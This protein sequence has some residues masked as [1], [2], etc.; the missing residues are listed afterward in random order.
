MKT[1]TSISNLWDKIYRNVSY[2]MGTPCRGPRISGVFFI[3][4]VLFCASTLYGGTHFFAEY[5]DFIETGWPLIIFM[6]FLFLC[7]C[8]LNHILLKRHLSMQVS[9]FLEAFLLITIILLFVNT[10]G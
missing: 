10:L 6:A 5:F 7:Y 4:I 2:L 3:L 8:L 9:V 1:I